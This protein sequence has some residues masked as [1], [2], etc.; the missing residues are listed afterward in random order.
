MTDLP[1]RALLR[2]D[3]VA[4]YFDVHSSTIRLWIEHGHLTAEKL[5]GTIRITRESI[6]KFRLKSRIRPG[7]N[8]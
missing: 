1:N 2:I 6:L 4:E 8:S 3:E 7:K 5:H